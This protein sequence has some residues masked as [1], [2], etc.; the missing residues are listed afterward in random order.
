MRQKL[1]QSAN[2]DAELQSMIMQNPKLAQLS[3]MASVFKGDFKTAFL[4]EAKRRGVDPFAIIN[5]IVKGI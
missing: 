5:A 2:P 4:N 3:G 1:A